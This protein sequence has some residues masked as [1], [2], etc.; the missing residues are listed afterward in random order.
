MLQQK[1]SLLCLYGKSN[2]NNIT[3]GARTKFKCF[4]YILDDPPGTAQAQ[5]NN[6]KYI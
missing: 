3:Y 5:D 1:N 6:L 2:R 4:Y